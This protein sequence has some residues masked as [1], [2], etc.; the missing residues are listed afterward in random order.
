MPTPPIA[1][2]ADGYFHPA[3]E[4]EV[5]ALVNYARSNSLQIRVRGATHSVALSIYTDPVAGLPINKTLEQV[6]PAGDNLNLAL[7]QMIALDWIV[8]Q[9][10][11]GFGFDHAVRRVDPIE[12]D[13][14]IEREVKIVAAGR[15]LL[16]RLV[17]R[18]AVNRIGVNAQRCGMRRAAHANLAIVGAGIVDQRDHLGLAGRVK[19][20][21]SRTGNRR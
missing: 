8:A 13:H 11:P 1:R 16:Q 5:V 14:L 2:A 4:A 12:R 9:V 17:D 19:I 6:P 18:L 15:D 20:S 3:S 21:V 10:D 7:D